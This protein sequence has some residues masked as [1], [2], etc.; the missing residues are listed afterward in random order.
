M[1]APSWQAD[2][3]SPFEQ[4]YKLFFDAGDQRQSKNIITRYVDTYF[5]SRPISLQRLEPMHIQQLYDFYMAQGLSSTTV[6]KVHA[7]IRKA[8]QHAVNLNMIPYNP[9]DRVVKPKKQKYVASFYDEEQVNRLLDVTKGESIYSVILL[10]AFYGLRRSEALGLRWKDI[11]FKNRTITHLQ[12]CRGV[13]CRRGEGTHQDRCQSA[14]PAAHCPGGGISAATAH[15]ARANRRLSGRR[16]HPKRFH[17][18]A[19]KRQAVLSQ[20]YHR[21]IRQIDR[22]LWPPQNSLP[23]SPP[24]R[25][26]HA[27]GQLLLF[28]RDSRLAG[29]FGLGKT[30]T[31]LYQPYNGVWLFMGNGASAKSSR[32]QIKLLHTSTFHH[33]HAP[34]SKEKYNN[35]VHYYMGA[36]CYIFDCDTIEIETAQG[37]RGG[38][39]PAVTQR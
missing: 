24:Q 27:I 16:L 23:R 29:A 37:V 38:L 14:Y 20:L 18:Q 3:Q 2:A 26:H 13:R 30:R 9:A 22:S 32:N 35:L 31:P 8:L 12:Y 36:T 17:M 39:G 5:A 4:G 33:P 15:G 34:K 25:R 28:E 10:T 11:N 7:N 21:A 1:V 6:L 19:G